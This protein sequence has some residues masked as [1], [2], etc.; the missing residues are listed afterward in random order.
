[1]KKFMSFVFVI[2]LCSSL[3]AKEGK[4]GVFG[5]LNYMGF[6]TVKLGDVSNLGVIS[7][8]T[9][10]SEMGVGYAIGGRYYFCLDNKQSISVGLGV[11]NKTSRYA[12][13]W[14][15]FRVS[16]AGYDATAKFTIDLNTTWLEMPVLYHYALSDQ[17]SLYGGG[18]YA[19]RVSSTAI[20]DYR[21]DYDG[22]TEGATNT[23]EAIDVNNSDYGL[24]LGGQYYLTKNNVINFDYSFGIADVLGRLK[25][26]TKDPLSQLSGFSIS[27]EYQ[28]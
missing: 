23:H 25:D 2:L 11:I 6:S 22:G 26:S 9:I 14:P 3:S 27:Y 18:Y 15:T 8:D 13:D 21:A 19:L 7:S 20:S 4:W 10:A 5:G 24:M 16:R 1:M 17:V 12:K 28:F